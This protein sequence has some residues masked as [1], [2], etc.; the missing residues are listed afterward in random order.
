MVLKSTQT[1]PRNTSVWMVQKLPFTSRTYGR[2]VRPEDVDA[3]AA[4]CNK[5]NITRL[6]LRQC[7]KPNCHALKWWNHRWFETVVF[8]QTVYVCILQMLRWLIAMPELPE[9]RQTSAET[10]YF[11]VLADLNW[12]QSA[13]KPS[14]DSYYRSTVNHPLG[15][16][17]QI[18]PTGSLHRNCQPNMAT[19]T[20]SAAQGFNL[21]VA[22]WY[23]HIYALAQ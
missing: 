16:R 22:E 15:G 23:L 19:T 7:W 20:A 17:Y 8:I 18:T 2:A 9:E 5:E 10:R 12:C 1:A 6:L 3:F 14:F 13:Y 11:E 21:Y 4:E